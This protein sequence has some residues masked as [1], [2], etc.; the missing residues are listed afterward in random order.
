[1]IREVAGTSDPYNPEGRS[2][3]VSRYSRTWALDTRQKQIAEAAR[4]L[5]TGEEAV[6][7]SCDFVFGVSPRPAGIRA[8]LRFGDSLGSD[9][10]AGRAGPG[11]VRRRGPHPVAA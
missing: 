9:P 11:K 7:M 5:C 10:A 1:M 4:P 2:A 3:P 8:R 6:P